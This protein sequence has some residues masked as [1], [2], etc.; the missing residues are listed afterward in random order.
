[1]TPSLRVVLVKTYRTTLVRTC[2]W[3]TSFMRGMQVEWV[4]RKQPFRHKIFGAWINNVYSIEIRAECLSED[5]FFEMCILFLKETVKQ[6]EQEY[7]SM[8][9]S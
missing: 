1:M 8:I 7:D 6:G 3:Y 5:E 4:R 2:G 9:V